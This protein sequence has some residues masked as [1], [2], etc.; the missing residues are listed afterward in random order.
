MLPIELYH[1]I[2]GQSPEVYRA[3]LALP[4][5][6]RSIDVSAR[7]DYMIMFGHSVLVNANAVVWLK[8]G[9]QH[10]AD[11]PAVETVNG[12]CI[13]YV[14]GKLHRTDGPA[15]ESPDGSRTWYV[16]GKLH[17]TDGPAIE[18]PDGSRMWY[19][20][21]MHHRVGGPAVERLDGLCAWYIHGALIR[22]GRYEADFYEK[23]ILRG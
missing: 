17:R 21:G 20:N 2:A 7:Y 13:W 16:N 12:M 11:G 15:I 9:K 3:M 5:F 8:D 1:V 10:R 19:V 6:A 14:N 22:T 4:V 18:N 23:L